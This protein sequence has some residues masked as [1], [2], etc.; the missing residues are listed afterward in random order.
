MAHDETKKLKPLSSFERGLLDALDE[1]PKL[2]QQRM[3]QRLKGEKVAG[4]K[5]AIADPLLR[6]LQAGTV[7]IGPTIAEAALAL[8][9]RVALWR[10]DAYCIFIAHCHCKGCGRKETRQADHQVYVRSR[11]TKNDPSNP[12]IYFPVRDIS[13]W[14]LPR[15]QISTFHTTFTCQ[16]CFEGLVCLPLPTPSEGDTGL[17][18]D[19]QNLSANSS[20][21]HPEPVQPASSLGED[22]EMSRLSSAN[23]LQQ[24]EGRPLD[25][26]MSV[27]P[28]S[29]PGLLARVSD[30]LSP[31][32][33]THFASNMPLQEG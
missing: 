28:E 20:S 2:H 1:D 4:P 18:E 6:K 29:K 8:E 3:L 25:F 30:W 17:H 22:L 9:Q 32:A 14:M 26:V 33:E 24:I 19:Q 11:N 27:S 5:T 15:L 31:T 12:F 23:S 16:Y 10:E 7:K 13:N 21:L